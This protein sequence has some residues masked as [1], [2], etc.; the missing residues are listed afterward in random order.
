MTVEFA[1]R[2]APDASVEVDPEYRRGLDGIKAGD[3][4]VLLTWL[5][6]VSAM[7]SGGA[8]GS[9]CA[10]RS[11][12]RDARGGHQAGARSVERR[13]TTEGGATAPPVS[14]ERVLVGARTVDRRH[15]HAE[16]SQVHRQLSAVVIPVVQHDRSQERDAR[17]APTAPARRA[18]S[19][20]V[21]ISAASSMPPSSAL[22]WPGSGPAPA[23]APP[24]WSAPGSRIAAPGRARATRVRRPPRYRS[25]RA[26]RARRASCAFACGRHGELVVR[27]ALEHPPRGLRFLFELLQHAIDHRHG[28][29][30]FMRE[31]LAASARSAHAIEQ[32]VQPCAS[33]S[34]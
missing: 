9:T 22:P 18:I 24:R 21:A 20:H 28:R 5:H 16:L 1:L 12:R 3:D 15:R 30:R 11:D 32:A 29:L 34:R 7:G 13:V 2:R 27:H 23:S 10:A 26:A 6:Q 25:R 31:A 17:H 14:R 19:R 8:R 4:L 33:P